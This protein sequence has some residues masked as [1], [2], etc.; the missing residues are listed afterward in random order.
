M[1]RGLALGGAFFRRVH[2]RYHRGCHFKVR[3]TW[4][5]CSHFSIWARLQLNL[6]GPPSV[7]TWRFAGIFSRNMAAF[8]L[9]WVPVQ[10]AKIATRTPSS[11]VASWRLANEFVMSLRPL[12]TTLCPSNGS[13]KNTSWHFGSTLAAPLFAKQSYA[14]TSGESRDVTLPCLSIQ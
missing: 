6:T 5:A 7:L 3:T 4:E 2:F 11:A 13:K 8:G 12:F 1:G 9:I 10:A 14:P